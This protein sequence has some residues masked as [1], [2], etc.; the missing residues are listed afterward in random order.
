MLLTMAD[1]SIPEKKPK[2]SSY[3]EPLTIFPARDHRQTFIL[4]HGRGSNAS[5]FGPDLLS[6]A[7]STTY[8]L[9]TAFPHAKFLFP[10]AS[11][12]RATIYKRSLINQWFDNW[13]L[14]AP[15]EREELQIDGLRETSA[16]IHD[17]L[18]TEID[19]VGAANVVLGGLS[20][21]CAASLIA[22]LTWPGEPLAAAFGMCGWLP[23]RGHMEDIARGTGSPENDDAENP[24][25]VPTEPKHLDNPSMRAIEYLHEELDIPVPS[26]PLSFQRTPLLLAHGTE[27]EKVPIVLGQEAASCMEA[28]GMNVTWKSY[29]ALAHWY[30]SEMLQD[31]VD[32]VREKTR[33]E[34][35]G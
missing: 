23:F 4:L 9:P 12:R 5:T 1:S 2:S 15:A 18:W 30:S 29:E 11:K 21:G 7:A 10:T 19:L 20:Q 31:V 34:V 32:F 33:W 8:I 17:L 24:F 3:P 6:T 28:M 27:D 16:Y 25:S 13:S 14:Q 22:L 35:E 26:P